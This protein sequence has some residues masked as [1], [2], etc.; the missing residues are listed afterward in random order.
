MQ[1]TCIF[2]TAQITASE[3]ACS[4]CLTAIQ[5]K[6]P[7]ELQPFLTHVLEN[8][9]PELEWIG[10]GYTLYARCAVGRIQQYKSLLRISRW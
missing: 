9:T 7:A 1:H 3:T 10:Q 8:A 4:G 2:C 6:T 5:D